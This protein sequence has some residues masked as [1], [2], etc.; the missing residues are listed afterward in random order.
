MLFNSCATI[1]RSI[2][3]SQGI[4]K[5]NNRD[6]HIALNHHSVE[7]HLQQCGLVKKELEPKENATDQ[8]DEQNQQAGDGVAADE[9]GSTVHGTEE[10]GFLGKLFAAFFGGF[11]INHASI[12]VGVN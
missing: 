10:V 5:Y 12:Q 8:V 1:Y 9:F 2:E 3:A 7:K 4:F 11:L 6:Y